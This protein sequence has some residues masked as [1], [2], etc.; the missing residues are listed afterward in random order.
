MSMYSRNKE[1]PDFRLM[2]GGMTTQN[3]RSI[4]KEVLAALHSYLFSVHSIEK[5]LSK[6]H[7]C[8]GSFHA[9]GCA[10]YLNNAV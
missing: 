1:A 4:S 7:Y 2:T 3:T 6:E 9:F 10:F 8:S 5:L